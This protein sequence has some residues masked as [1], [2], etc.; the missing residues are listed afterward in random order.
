MPGSCA[1][2]LFEVAGSAPYPVV[3]RCLGKPCDKSMLNLGVIFTTMHTRLFHN[4]ASFVGSTHE[5]YL[6]VDKGLSV[7]ENTLVGPNAAALHCS[8]L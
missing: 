4:Y 1:L 7:L 3:S 6:R 2:P 5:S 8:V